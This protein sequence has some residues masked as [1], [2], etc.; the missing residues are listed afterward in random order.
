M[1][2]LVKILKISSQKI[3]PEYLPIL[4]KRKK[5]RSLIQVLIMFFFI[6]I[7]QLKK[8]FQKS[9]HSL[10]TTNVLGMCIMYVLT[11]FLLIFRSK[12][13]EGREDWKQTI[14]EQTYKQCSSCKHPR[15]FTKE[16]KNEKHSIQQCKPSHARRPPSQTKEMIYF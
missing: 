10:K 12:T 11:P 15:K 14:R 2:S 8:S 6:Q 16:E 4:R 9:V 13:W 7:D 5:Q 3:I 1:T